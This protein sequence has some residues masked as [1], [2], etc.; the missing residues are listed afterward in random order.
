[1]DNPSVYE[2]LVSAWLKEKNSKELTEISSEL[3]EQLRK[4]VSE[5]RHSIRL[6]TR[7]SITEELKRAEIETLTRL[8]N[9]L[10][11]MRYEKIIS[12]I[13]NEKYPENMLPFER[14]F[15]HYVNLAISEHLEMI[16]MIST[17]FRLPAVE[18]VQKYV[19][20]AFL[21][22]FPKIVG[23]DLREYGP[24]KSGDIAILPRENARNLTK[25]GIAKQIVIY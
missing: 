3:F 22:D 20:V 21:Q 12:H 11:R 2:K 13:L 16:D 5:L 6:S 1:M 17:S 18:I 8:A 25:Q 9:S 15:Y 7:D 10:L 19:V 23:E 4:H 24:F 14:Q